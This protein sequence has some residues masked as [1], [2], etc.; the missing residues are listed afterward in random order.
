MSGP[1]FQSAK[2]VHQG[3]PMAPFLLNMVGES[4]MKMVLQAQQN[5]LMSGL[6][7]S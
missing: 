6:A 7:G 3:D 1:Y 4:L 5:G 2:G